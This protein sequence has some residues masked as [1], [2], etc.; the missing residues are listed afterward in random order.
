V[1][2]YGADVIY[3]RNSL[4]KG[5]ENPYSKE[6]QIYQEKLIKNGAKTHH[7][8]E[9]NLKIAIDN[10]HKHQLKLLL[11]II[12]ILLSHP[13]KDVRAF[14]LGR[15][16][17][18]ITE[19]SLRRFI[20]KDLKEMCDD[21]QINVNLAAQDSLELISGLVHDLVLPNIISEVF[22]VFLIDLEKETKIRV[23]N[24]QFLLN[25]SIHPHSDPNSLFHSHNRFIIAFVRKFRQLNILLD[26]TI[27]S[28]ELEELFPELEDV[29]NFCMG[30][31][32]AEEIIPY[33]DIANTQWKP[34][35]SIEK[36]AN[37]YAN[38]FREEGHLHHL[39]TYLDDDDYRVRRIGVNALLSVAEFLL[40]C[41]DEKSA[42]NINHLNNPYLENNIQSLSK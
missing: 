9:K 24:L 19:E 13:Q 30:N 34:T 26:K 20:I 11:E 37:I 42:E 28:N 21:P 14:S 35:D 27:F 7:D 6:W 33:S 8:L 40:N 31:F 10:T 38:T 25:P 32:T 2:S 39:K 3:E 16:Y 29:E 5:F 12:F 36:I 18:L 23:R 22:T 15:L 4:K 17:P 1:R 41:S